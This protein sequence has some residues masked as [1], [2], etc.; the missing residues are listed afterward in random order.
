MN[1]KVSIELPERYL[2]FVEDMVRSGAYGSLSEIVQE[3]IR[4]RMLSHREEPAQEQT[5]AVS[6]MA[7]EIRR[8]MASPPDQWIEMDK[9]DT[10]FDD[11]R[12]QLR[13]KYGAE[14]E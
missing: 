10:M 1:I 7:G 4:D 14:R 5:D 2:E 8:R 6:A 12:T 3:D 13:R 11:L 9:N